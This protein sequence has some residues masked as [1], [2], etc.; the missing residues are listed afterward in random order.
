MTYVEFI[1]QRVCALSAKTA[2]LIAYGQNITAGSHL[3][4][5]TRGFK[6]G[7]GGLALNTPNVENT[8][9][10]LGFGIMLR[11]LPAVFFCKQQDFLLLGID[12]MVNTYAAIRHRPGLGSFTI[13]AIVVDSGFEGPQS[14][15]HNLSDFCSLAQAPGYLITNQHDA[16]TILDR[17]LVAPGFRFI[18]I[19]QRLFRTDPISFPEVPVVFEN[20]ALFRYAQ[21]GDATVVSFNLAFPQ[22]YE[23]WKAFSAHG[24][25]AS[26][27]SVNNVWEIDWAPLLRDI[28]VT[29]RL[30]I[31]DDGKSARRQSDSFLNAVYAEGNLRK[32]VRVDRP[33][34]PDRFKPHADQLVIN[35]SAILVGLE[36]TSGADQISLQPTT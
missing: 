12:H 36:L 33:F 28:A 25:S 20:G 1:N 27:F 14:S 4:G 34:H 22:A 21:G 29:G 3:S 17:H 5:L 24:K 26:L 35:I 6:P 11:G 32:L 16:E 7:P 23:T 2:R 31:L 13:F 15:L 30:V 18:G 8:L 9:V 10:G 19:S